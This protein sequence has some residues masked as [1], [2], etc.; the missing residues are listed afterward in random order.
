MDSEKKTQRELCLA[1]RHAL[2]SQVR[3]EY[4]AVICRYLEDL[5]GAQ[6]AKTIFSY[7]AAGDEVDLSSFHA[8]A[9]ERGKTL[10]F[11]VSHGRGEMEVYTPEGP[12]SWRQGRY[13]IWEPIPE[14]SRLIPPQELDVILLP[15]VGFDS[16]GGRLGHGGGYYD[17]YLPLCPQAVRILVAF[18]AQRLEWVSARSWD[19]R[20][21]I[22]VTEAGVFRP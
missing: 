3:S 7:R 4:S 1:R 2:S 18:E 6:K 9:A 8:W 14:C 19:Q 5:D 22:L 10:A 20:V 11:P 17:R 16:Q 13:G 12:D 15:C 21:D